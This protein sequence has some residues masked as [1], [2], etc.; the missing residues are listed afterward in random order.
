MPQQY[1]IPATFRHKHRL[2]EFMHKLNA[3][4]AD[5]PEM[6][7][8]AVDDEV[9]VSLLVDGKFVEDVIDYIDSEYKV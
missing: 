7:I 2:A 4:R 3:L 8:T 9:E 1:T 5:Y 6:Y